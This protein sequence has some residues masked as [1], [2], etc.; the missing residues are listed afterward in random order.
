MFAMAISYL[1]GWAMATVDGAKKEKAEWPPH[2]DRVYMALAAA[3]F[4]SGEDESEGAALRW[5]E[6]QQPPSIAATVAEQRLGTTSYVPV[7]DAKV[8]RKRPTTNSLSKLKDTGLDVLPEYRSRQPRSFPVAVPHHPII[9]LIWPE[10]IPVEHREPL[11]QL[12]AKL[13]HVGHSASLVQAWIDDAPAPPTWHPVSAGI[14]RLRLRTPWAGRLADLKRLHNRDAVIAYADM[15]AT[16]ETMSGREKAQMKEAIKERFGHSAPRSQRP[17]SGGWIGYA[18]VEG[19]SESTIRTGLFDPNLVVLTLT[20]KRLSLPATLKLTE[21]LRGTLL[22]ACPQ[23]PEQQIPEWFSGHT[24]DGRPSTEPHMGL[25]PL[26][27]SGSEHA[28]GRIMGLALALPRSLAADEASRCL[29]AFLYDDDTGLP[30]TT[31]LFAGK[32]L[33]CHVEMEI[34]EKPP[35]NLDARRWTSPSRIWASV[36]PVVLD[37]HFD[38][39]DKWSK[40][41]ESVKDAC[42]RIDLPRPREVMLHPVSLVEGVPH[43][44]E[45]PYLTRKSDGGRRHHSHA[46]L[47]FD[48]PVRG[49]VLI[50]AG[51]FRGYGLCRPM[52]QGM[53]DRD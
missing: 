27:F 29:S 21:T 47:I 9:H 3:W 7:N 33:E 53:H 42:E 25:L 20:G 15:N 31:R 13:T 32:W 6:A 34:R 14:A 38:G 36:T 12:A 49:P 28:D 43:A 11:H 41:A 37:R 39:K 17:T 35:T 22:A 23:S 48:E 2:P 45:F 10:P 18:P 46:V 30:K 16:L 44:R 51:R 8:S 50:G 52:D 4:E 24:A 40:A 19:T 5:L 1:N 26:P